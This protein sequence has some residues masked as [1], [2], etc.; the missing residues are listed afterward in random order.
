M[1]FGGGGDG[2]AAAAREDAKRQEEERQARIREGQAAIDRNFTQY[3]DTYYGNYRNA[4]ASYY[5]P[6]VEEQYKDAIDKL[7][8]TLAGRGILESS[9]GADAFADLQKQYNDQQALIANKSADTANELK[10]KVEQAKSDLYGLN[11]S[12]ADP[13]GIAARAAS[14]AKALAA[15]SAFSPLGTIFSSVLTPATAYA[16]A[17]SNSAGR[18]PTAG[19]AAPSGS[20]SSKVVGARQ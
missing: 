18:I 8:A 5:T 2:G 11:T 9:V 10:A 7:T 15:P 12:M 19:V 3:D 6:Q 1:G 16:Q 17:Y 4:Y 13:A 20:G 14:E